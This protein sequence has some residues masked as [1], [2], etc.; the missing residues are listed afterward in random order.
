MRS[1]NA[2]P[3]RLYGLRKT[4][5]VGCKLR[6]VVS[7]IGS[8]VYEISRFVHKVLS[9]YVLSL[10][11]NMKDSYQFVDRIKSIVVDNDYQLISLDV[12]S[13]F[14]NV[15]RSL[16][17]KIIDDR[18]EDMK[19]FVDLDRDLFI[20]LVNFCF[21]SGYFLFQKNFYL[22]NAGC[23][24]GSPASPSIAITAVDFVISKA[25]ENLDFEIPV[26]AAYVDDLFLV[27]P[28]NKVVTV[29][30]VFN[31]V[32]A[33]IQFTV[34]NEVDGKLPFLDVLVCRTDSGEL[35]TSWY[36][37]PYSSERVLNFKSNHPLSQKLGVAQGFFNRAIRL[38]HESMVSISI[39]KVRHLL[40]NNN[41]PRSV[42]DKC[43]KVTVDRVKNN[44]R[45]NAG[46]RGWSFCRFPF[47][48]GLSPR[49]GFL[50]R[51]TNCKL[52]FY[53]VFKVKDL[54]SRLKDPVDKMDRSFVVYKIPCTCGKVYIGQ[55]KQK[56]KKRLY[57]HSVDCRPESL[58]KP[59]RTA[60]ADHHFDREH[61]F[62]FDATEILDYETHYFKRNVSEMFFI[63]VFDCV[64]YRSDTLSLS[65]SYCD[66]IESVKCLFR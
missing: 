22:Q 40:L 25:L 65:S 41:Y 45:N 49:I 27:V 66:I 7:N 21:D 30:Q 36:Q 64:N 38:S 3:P 37:K 47:I 56:L 11:F 43:Q 12:V 2:L 63:K 52:V 53:N 57:Q 35:K 10:K 13:L 26:L 50:F 32:D 20:D 59:N 62:Q 33:D 9:P 61:N 16:I 58:L 5:K 8:P 14:T 24:M 4:H 28:K 44:L 19:E 51:P 15:K 54:Y 60:L 1:Y 17:I 55:T 46:L 42:V 18:W 48:K 31:S 6:P 23:G 29:L 34:E 39:N